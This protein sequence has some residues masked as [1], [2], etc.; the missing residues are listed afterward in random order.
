MHFNWMN[1]KLN[2]VALVSK[3][4]YIT[5][6]VFNTHKPNYSKSEFLVSSV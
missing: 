4:L 1:K 2:S 3:H 6:P 5:I